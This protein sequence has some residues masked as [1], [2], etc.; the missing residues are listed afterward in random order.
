MDIRIR[1]ETLE[2][3]DKYFMIFFSAVIIAP[4]AALPI[5]VWGVPGAIFVIVC[6]TAIILFWT[7][8]RITVIEPGRNPPA[9]TGRDAVKMNETDTIGREDE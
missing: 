4:V 5:L 6:A 2:R 3:W 9:Q 1:R 7:N 8:L